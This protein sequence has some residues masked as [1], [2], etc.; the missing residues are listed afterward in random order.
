MADD[1]NVGELVIHLKD[2][3]VIK[4]V[5]YSARYSSAEFRS[6]P[7]A[8]MVSHPLMCRSLE[9]DIDI[10]GVA[11]LEGGLF[12]AQANRREGTIRPIGY[13]L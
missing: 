6:L 7:G 12:V 8:R 4:F 11:V 1:F 10:G 2:E 9:E 13:R 5:I 3:R